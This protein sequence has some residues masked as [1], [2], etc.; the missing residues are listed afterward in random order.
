MFGKQ[1]IKGTKTN[2]VT[3]GNATLYCGDCFDVVPKLDIVA[4]AVIS[5]MPFGVTDC[6]WDIAPPL[7][8]FW[9][10]VEER[11][12]PSAN[13]VL[14]GCGRFTHELYNSN[15]K[16]F[17]YDMIWVKNN[18]VGFLNSGLMPLRNHEAVL[19]FGQPGYQRAA[20]Y[21]PQKVSGGRVGI[22]K[23]KRR[24][25]VYRSIDGGAKFYD[26]MQH[27]CSVLHFKGEK[28][29][30]LHP[31]LKPVAL[32]EWLVRTYTNEGDTVIDPFMGVGSTGVACVN[33]GRS[34]I[35]IERDIDYFRI[36]C[37]RIKQ[38]YAESKTM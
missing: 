13:I 25:G 29:K 26:G 38:A 33:T 15:P 7:D 31:T 12:K 11:I 6:S 1:G 8:L 36:A 34:F 22:R 23:T 20:V 35:G 19:V 18:K 3:I 9:T 2:R 21:N 37:E 28:D 32:M 4:D 10:M 27:P 17:R 14:F 30:G 24:G 16:W 5:D